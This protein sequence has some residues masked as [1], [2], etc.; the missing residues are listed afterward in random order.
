MVNWK[1]LLIVYTAI[2]ERSSL[3]SYWKVRTHDGLG[4]LGMCLRLKGV[5]V[6]M[7]VPLTFYLV[8]KQVVFGQY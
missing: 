6:M 4:S 3:A 2:L 1:E 8:R 5:E 7:L